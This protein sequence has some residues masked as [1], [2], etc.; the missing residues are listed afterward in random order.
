MSKSK[1]SPRSSEGIVVR[2]SRACESRKT[3]GAACSCKPSYEAWA[4]SKRD[5]FKV[6]RTFT[7]HAEAKRWRT[8]LLK[9]AQDNS[10]RKPSS[11]LVRQATDE[12]VRLAE[13]GSIR[14]RS[15][16]AYKPSALRGIRQ[17][18]ALR[19]VPAIGTKRLSEVTRSDA[20]TL[21]SRWQAE[22]LSA[23][24]IRN[25]INALRALYRDA[26]VLTSGEVAINPT[27]GLRLPAVRGQRDRIAS[28]EEAAR[29]IAAMP[30]AHDRALWGTAF[31]AG[32]R[33]GEVKAITWDCVDLASGV[34]RVAASWDQTEGRVDP[35]SRSGVRVVP[36]IGLLRPLLVEWGLESQRSAGLVF[37]RNGSSPF[38]SSAANDRARRAWGWKLAPPV[39]GTPRSWVGSCPEPMEPIGLH[40]ARH[41]FASYCIAADLNLKAISTYMGHSSV[42]FTLDRYGHLLPDSHLDATAK[43]DAFLTRADTAARIASLT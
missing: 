40:E 22:G 15:G 35:K 43:L 5:G 10:L 28:P 33:H 7:N 30:T 27:T 25:T 18:F 20:Q 36:I 16:D 14:N 26:D 2:H 38:S 42:A 3:K 9:A 39:K 6:R 24:S 8:T 29:L 41:T 31:Y 37:G 17:A 1:A 23:S 13:E 11:I 12:W 19:I 32:L 21:V 34:L 4:W